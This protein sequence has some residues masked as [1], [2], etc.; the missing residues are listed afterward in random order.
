MDLFEYMRNTNMEKESP[1]AARLRP[2]TLDEVVGQ[3]HL[4]GPGALLGRIAQGGSIPNM[5]FYGP[6][7]VGKT[8]AARIIARA[9]GKKPV[10]PAW[11]TQAIR[12]MSPPLTR[13]R[14]RPDIAA[15]LHT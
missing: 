4:L 1:L 8:T 15:V 11:R 5:I 12:R 14:A 6:S 10:P 2:L 13:A 3:Q 9:A 7:G